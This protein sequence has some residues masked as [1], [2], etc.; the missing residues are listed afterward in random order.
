MT[1]QELLINYVWDDDIEIQFREN[2]ESVDSKVVYTGNPKFLPLIFTSREVLGLYAYDDHLVI[3]V[4][5]NKVEIDALVN[6]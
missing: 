2:E 4:K 1:L 6:E 3:C 5:A